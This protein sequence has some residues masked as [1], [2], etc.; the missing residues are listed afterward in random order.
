MPQVDYFKPAGIPLSNIN[1]TLLTLTELEAIRL[2]DLEEMEQEKAAKKMKISQPTLS[3]LL[4]SARKKIAFA[5][6]NG[7]AIKIQGGVYQM[8]EQISGRG[9]GRGMG[10]GAGMGRG[11]G[12]G[13]GRGGGG[14]G[15]MGGFAAG[16]GGYCVCPKCGYKV[17]HQVGVPCYQQKC[18]KCGS[19]M[20]RG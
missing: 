1:E 8:A 12:L 7:Q 4:N 17:E 15:R 2:V 18:P 6:V 11:R 13:A 14:M 19:P 5:L 3:R 9:F 16:P 10:R 20:T